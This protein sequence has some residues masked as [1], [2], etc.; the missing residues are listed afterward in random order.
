MIRLAWVALLALAG[1]VHGTPV[2]LDGC[3]IEIVTDSI[4]PAVNLDSLMARCPD[5]TIR[6]EMLRP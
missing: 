1:C 6:T 3:T 5:M 2:D 4:R